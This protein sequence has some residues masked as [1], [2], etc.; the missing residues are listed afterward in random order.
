MCSL[1]QEKGNMSSGLISRLIPFMG[2]LGFDLRVEGNKNA[3]DI[4]SPIRKDFLDQVLAD[5]QASDEKRYAAHVVS[6]VIEHQALFKHN[7][8]YL[9]EAVDT[10]GSASATDQDPQAQD[11]VAANIAVKHNKFHAM[12]AEELAKMLASRDS[13]L[14]FQIKRLEVERDLQRV[15][16]D[17]EAANNDMLA[18]AAASARVKGDVSKAQKE[19]EKAMKWLTA[20]SA[21]LE[22]IQ[23]EENEEEEEYAPSDEETD[24][25]QGIPGSGGRRLHGMRKAAASTK[26]RIKSQASAKH[27]PAK[28]DKASARG[29]RAAAASK[30]KRG[31]DDDEVDESDETDT[32]NRLRKSPPSTPAKKGK[33]EQQLSFNGTLFRANGVQCKIQG[34][35]EGYI[36]MSWRPM[37]LISFVTISIEF[38]KPGGTK[39]CNMLA[40][41]NVP[42]PG[43]GSTTT[44]FSPEGQIVPEEDVDPAWIVRSDVVH[45]AQGNKKIDEQII[46]LMRMDFLNAEDRSII[47][48]SGF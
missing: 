29:K 42:E 22:D 18:I 1:L 44:Y 14:E 6:A 16:A 10:S 12:Y 4:V 21:K 25:G 17:Y 32:G 41:L 20:M 11:A 3:Y 31:K 46:E 38:N 26:A 33:K 9:K 19:Y 23:E 24:F 47:Q 27:P 40:M 43:E 7:I 36:K 37:R 28:P 39:G 48:G 15:K 5:T 13:W 30:K 34:H 35:G 2:H 45:D 8:I